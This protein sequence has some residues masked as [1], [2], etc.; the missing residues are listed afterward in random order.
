MAVL[1]CYCH[2]T[3]LGDRTDLLRSYHQEFRVRWTC[4]KCWRIIKEPESIDLYL[5]HSPYDSPLN[6]VPG[7]LGYVRRDL[8][9]TIGQD[10]FEKHFR[11]GYVFDEAGKLCENF[12][13]FRGKEILMI[14]GGKQ[15]T[16][17]RCDEC[18]GVLYFALGKEY[19]LRRDLTGA[20]L[21]GPS[22][23]GG[24]IVSEEIGKRIWAE[25]KW[26]KVSFARLPVL[27]SPQDGLDEVL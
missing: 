20:V 21:Y 15:S 1:E 4:K 7:L 22:Q 23:G 9:D 2:I 19:V 5:D 13:S 10:L 26:K 17:R 18:G 12:R 6:S 16:Y 24:F 14:R 8:L 25:K 11:I 27:D 3:H